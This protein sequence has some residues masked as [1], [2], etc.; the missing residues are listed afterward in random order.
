M[1]SWLVRIVIMNKIPGKTGFTLIEVLLALSVFSLAGL[2]LLN[3]ADTHFNSLN[4]IED[5][6]VADWV[7]ANRL[8][9]VNLDVSWPPKNNKNGKVEMASREWFWHQKVVKTTDDDMREVTIVVKLDEKSDLPITSLK[10]Y[11]SKSIGQ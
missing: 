10:T 7:A 6:M 3:T 9:E 8:V 2:A 4:N 1:A 5:K 11:V